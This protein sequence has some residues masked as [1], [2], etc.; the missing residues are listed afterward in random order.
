MTSP[1]GGGG[2]SSVR[3]YLSG[4]VAA[5]L[6]VLVVVGVGGL[7]A[8]VRGHDSV[9][10]LTEEV[11]PA[12]EA[13]AAVL[14]D[15]TDAETFLWGWGISGDEALLASYRH[16]V[17]RYHADEKQLERLGD[18]DA[19]VALL[20]DD[21]TLAADTWFSAYVDQRLTQTT[22]PES[23]DAGLFERGLRLFGDVRSTNTAVARELQHLTTDADDQSHDTER[24]LLIMLAVLVVLGVAATW[25]VGRRVGRRVTEPL[26]ALEQTAHDLAAG[27]HEARAPVDGPREVVQVASAVNRMAA[28]NERAR[29]VESHVVEQLRALDAVKSDF[30]SNVSHELRTPLTSILGYLELLEEEQR[31]RPDGAEHEMVAAA[32][33]NVIRLGELID[34]LLALT[35]SE[36]TRTDLVP[37][38]LAALVRDIVTDLRVASSQQGVDIRLGLP[39]APV[40]VLADAGQIARVVTNLVS[41]A[42]K[43]S[44]GDSEVVVTVLADGSEAVMTVEDHGIGIPESE[45]DQLGSRFYRASN[46]VGLGIAGSGLGLRI[47]QAIVEN[48]HGTVDLR[49]TQG[50]G[51]TVWVRIPRADPGAA[52]ASTDGNT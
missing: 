5:N 48:H 26:S 29:A 15:L 42:V 4:V 47:V 35:R 41:N 46:A 16:A 45:L 3:R 23:F 32:K 18:I 1:D 27:R 6:L 20:V 14:Q 30:V 2:R 24:N 49:S 37:T 36:D 19:Q 43:F 40:V 34:D 10:Y 12:V 33:R 11:E 8:T 52:A 9:H 22:G 13:N 28:E 17:D 25:L 38:D 50:V 7:V 51:T 39:G 21:F 31:D 44:Q